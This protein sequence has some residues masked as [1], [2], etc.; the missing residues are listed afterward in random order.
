MDRLRLGRCVAYELS[1]ALFREG[2]QPELRAHLD[3]APGLKAAASAFSGPEA[4]AE[5]HER[6]LGFEVFA[7][8]GVFLGMPARIGGPVADDLAGV[9]AQAGVRPSAESPDSIVCELEFLAAVQDREAER[10]FLDGHLLRWLPALVWALYRQE[11]A[12]YAELGRLTLELALEHRKALGQPE[13]G[14]PSSI[15]EDR[16]EALL[17]APETGL[18]QIAEFLLAPVQSGLFLSRREISRL[19]QV[20]ALPSGFGARVDRLRNLLRSAAEFD[21]F[22]AMTEAL[23]DL[24]AAAERFYA[25]PKLEGRGRAWLDRLASARRL[26]ARLQEAVRQTAAP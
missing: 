1:A 25:D 16:S 21:R 5:E 7:Y 17:S 10:S 8:E 24:I 15:G 2:P 14:P 19:A 26:A 23:L 9:Y 12:F 13:P 3:A 6:V 11:S 20:E 4:A 22:G 18:E